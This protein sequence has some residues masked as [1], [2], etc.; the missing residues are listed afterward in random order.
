MLP[1]IWD[2]SRKVVTGKCNLIF[3]SVIF[4]C[5][6]GTAT[7]VIVLMALDNKMTKHQLLL[8]EF[9]LTLTVFL[10]VGQILIIIEF[11]AFMQLVKSLQ[12]FMNS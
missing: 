12:K 8:F 11:T 5:E 3:Y 6:G 10:V 9:K 4:R 1:I 2:A 7:L